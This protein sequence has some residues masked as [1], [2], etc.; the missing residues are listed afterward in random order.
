M[1]ALKTSDIE[2]FVARPDPS[3]AIVL[4]FGPDAGLVSERADAIV[5]AS[6]DDPADPFA[7]VRLDGDTLASDPARLLD[8]ATTIP[9]F[10]GRRAIRVRAGSR[11]IVPA[12]E[13]VLGAKLQDCRVVI[14]AGDLK[15]GAAL[16]AVCERAKTAVAIPCYADA[17]RDVGR[18]VDEEM[19]AADL[20]IA[21]D[22]R[23]AL[24]PLLG[25]DRRASRAELRKLALYA[26]GQERVEIDDVTAVVADASALALDSLVDAAFAGRLADVEKE[27]AKAAIAGTNA[28]AIVGAALRQIERLHAL[29]LDVENG[30]SASAVVESQPGIHFRRK[31]LIEA[32]LKAWTSERLAKAMSMLAE[33]SLDARKQS[34]LGETIAHR[35]LS[36]I[37]RSAARR[38]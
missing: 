25:G 31:P 19:R 12:I 16:R 13:N 8:E 1:V 14:E 6:V 4:V 2:S 15:R 28:S 33:A 17:D 18:I 34:D 10:G 23:A 20:S 27:F 24:I 29:R 5:R 36:L 37:A 38:E 11:N 7:L 9:L 22:A 26:N 21:P 32:A 35:A 30:T 3:R